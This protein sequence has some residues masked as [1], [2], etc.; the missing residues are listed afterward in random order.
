MA[1]LASSVTTGGAR[2]HA[3]TKS[4][5]FSKENPTIEFLEKLELVDII[6]KNWGLK[7]KFLCEEL[8]SEKEINAVNK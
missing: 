1:S 5:M 7:I 8:S 3:W 6:L 2:K 4:H